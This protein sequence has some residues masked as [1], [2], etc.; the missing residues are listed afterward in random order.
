MFFFWAILKLKMPIFVWILRTT[1]LM[2][3]GMCYLMRPNCLFNPSKPR[4]QPIPSLLLI[5]ALLPL[6]HFLLS[7]CEFLLKWF[8][9]CTPL[10]RHHHMCFRPMFLLHLHHLQVSPISLLLIFLWLMFLEIP[11]LIRMFSSRMTLFF[12]PPFIVCSN[13]EPSSPQNYNPFHEQH[14]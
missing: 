11:V 8:R 10:I 3:L 6:F 12:L 4:A 14:L 7:P 13:W 1:K 9:P 5:C 2:C